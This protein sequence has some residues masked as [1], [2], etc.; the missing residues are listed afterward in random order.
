MIYMADIA[1]LMCDAFK[2][3]ILWAA[4]IYN[5]SLFPVVKIYGILLVLY[6]RFTLVNSWNKIWNLSVI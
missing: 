1:V 2:I 6:E 4:D 3:E 5:P